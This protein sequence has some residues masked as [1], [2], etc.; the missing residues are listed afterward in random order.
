MVSAYQFFYTL[1]LANNQHV[2]MSYLEKEAVLPESWRYFTHTAAICRFSQS[3]TDGS[4][5]DKGLVAIG[6]AN[7]ATMLRNETTEIGKLLKKTMM[8]KYGPAALKQQ[9][10]VLDTICDAHTVV[11]PNLWRFWI[12]ASRQ[13]MAFVQFHPLALKYVFDSA[14]L[15]VD[16]QGDWCS[17]SRVSLKCAGKAGRCEWQYNCVKKLVTLCNDNY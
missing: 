15:Q 1:K 13:Y 8:E 4:D 11:N 3:M 14:S 16:W 10:M 12:L 5:P 2:I 17:E 6:L 7:Q 9:Y